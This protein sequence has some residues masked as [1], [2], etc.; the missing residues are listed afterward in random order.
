MFT[1]C[2]RNYCSEHFDHT[3]SDHTHFDHT[4]FIKLFTLLHVL[5]IGR[6]NY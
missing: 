5:K 1:V 2:K 3:N 4:N 6:H